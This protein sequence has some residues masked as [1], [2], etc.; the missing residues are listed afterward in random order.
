MENREQ[1]DW[2]ANLNALINFIMKNVIHVNNLSTILI[3]FMR[4]GWCLN[5]CHD[6][7]AWASQWLKL[8]LV[9]FLEHLLS[10]GVPYSWCCDTLLP[11]GSR[12]QSKVLEKNV[13]LDIDTTLKG[14]VLFLDAVTRAGFVVMKYRGMGIFLCL[15]QYM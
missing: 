8:L 15:F 13:L 4:E 2:M 12:L 1:W 6:Y 11:L 14:N 10:P 5:H 9:I 7:S 3:Y